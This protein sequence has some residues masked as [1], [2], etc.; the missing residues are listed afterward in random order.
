MAGVITDSQH[1]RTQRAQHQQYDIAFAFAS[2]RSQRQ[3]HQR[4]YAAFTLIVGTQ[5]ERNVFECDHQ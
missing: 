2:D 4:Q 1:A 5:H 3:C